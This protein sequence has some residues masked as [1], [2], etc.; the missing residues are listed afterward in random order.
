[1]KAA[2]TPQSCVVYRGRRFG[3]QACPEIHEVLQRK[4]TY[5]LYP[6]TDAKDLK[7]VISVDE[8]PYDIIILDGTWKQAASLY[9]QNEFLHSLRKVNERNVTVSVFK[10]IV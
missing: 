5:L 8:G 4:Q 3:Q 2:L 1:L 9:T 6:R 10:W 7:E